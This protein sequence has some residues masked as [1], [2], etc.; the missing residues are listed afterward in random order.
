MSWR[1]NRIKSSTYFA[2]ATVAVFAWAGSAFGDMTLT[3]EHFIPGIEARP[4]YHAVSGVALS[5]DESRLYAAHWQAGIVQSNDPI[6]VY[7]TADYS[8]LDRIPGGQCVGNVVTSNDGRYVYGPEYYGGYIHRYDTWN[9]NADT[10]IGLGSWA[11]DVWKTP[12]GDRAVVKYNTANLALIDIS[13][14]HFS[15]IESF[16]AG[17]PVA[18]ASAAFSD[19]GQ[20]MYLSAG[21][22]QTA[23]PTL[24]DVELDG[25]FHISRE[26]ELTAGANQDWNLAGVVRYGG[27]LVVGDRTGSKLYIVDEATFTKTGEV[28]LPDSPS[29][30]ALHPDGQHLFILCADS[31]TLSVMN[32]STMTEEASLSG[33]H[34]GLCDIAFTA[35]GTKAYIAHGDQAQGGV[36][37]VNVVPEPKPPAYVDRSNT[38]G[39]E[40]GTKERPFST[41]QRGINIVSSGGIV[42]VARG[43]YRES[44]LIEDKRVQIKGGYL[45]GTYPGTGNF[46]EGSRNPDPKTNN[47]VIDGGGAATEVAAQNAAAEGSVLSG[48]KIRD[49]GATFRGVIRQG[50]ISQ[51][52]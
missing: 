24:I 7:S 52:E 50:V 34:L 31:G 18:N 19:N 16:N 38:T 26:L 15:K 1:A 44:L 29:D 35:D 4:G 10:A 11:S 45:G 47:T 32:L 49:G 40:D 37:I 6:A 20:H 27:T 8:L 48:F 12:N 41:I 25:T 23:G 43:T 28:S 46:D 2:L 21:S 30:I 14:D 9:G 42:K 3:F 51:S 36:S 5:P 22:S 13:D 17:R 33:L 39:V